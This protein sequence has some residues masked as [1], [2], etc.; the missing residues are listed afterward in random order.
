MANNQQLDSHTSHKPI[1]EAIDLLGLA[2]IIWVNRKM[3]LSITL[4]SLFIG[5]LVALLSP[6]EFTAS[7][8]FIPQTGTS[9]K[10]GSSLGGL[11]SLAGINLGGISIGSEIP[12]ALYPKFAGAVPFKKALL[13]TE[14]TL[15]GSSEKI[16]Y[17]E[18]FTKIHSPGILSLLK[19]YTIGLP[20]KIISSVRG[21]TATTVIEE[22]GELIKVSREEFGLFKAL[23]SQLTISPNENEGF[24]SIS[25]TM[26]D[27]VM[28]AEMVKAT[29]TLLQKEVI[30]YKIQNAREQLK[31]TETQFVE[32]KEEFEKIQSRLAN[33]RDR[34]QNIV[35]A[36]VNNELQRLQSEY[37][38]AFNI[39]NELAKQLE[40]AKLQV[41][42]DTPIFSVI[43][44]VTVPTEKSSPNRPL[45]LIASIVLGIIISLGIVF[46]SVFF[47]DVK[48]KW[49]M[50]L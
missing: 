35:S 2:K 10:T 22:K 18:Y 27:P 6:K 11:A 15:S 46:G 5:L 13:E 47:K 26:P 34:N 16:T 36:S 9:N 45:I 20:G 24:V 38:F 7:S 40:Q 8:A 39:Y 28:A 30:A 12:P 14:I 17:K 41:S 21:N 37:D 3:I 42:K 23:E 33:F 48:K 1:E 4:F 31:F 25:F 44:P 19:S 50:S 32:K 29:E 49:E 43:Q